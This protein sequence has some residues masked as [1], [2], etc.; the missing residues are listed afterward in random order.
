MIDVLK[1]DKHEYV[2][3]CAA[4]ALS[5]LG[6]RAQAALPVLK[7]G[8][9][10]PDVNVRNAFQYAVKAIEGAKEEAVPAEQSKKQQAI[11][12]RIGRFRKAQAEKP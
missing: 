10:D 12:E 9:H 8:I 3:R 5:R 1:T 11:Q 7:E 2:R 4:S 6:Q